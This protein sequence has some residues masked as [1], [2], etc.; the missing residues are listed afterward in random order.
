MSIKAIVVGII[1][2]DAFE[3][4]VTLSF[5]NIRCFLHCLLFSC[6]IL[7]LLFILL[8]LLLSFFPKDVDV[9]VILLDNAPHATP[10]I[11]V[12]PVESLSTDSAHLIAPYVPLSSDLTIQHSTRVRK[13]PSYL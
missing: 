7:L 3:S 5:G 13:V 8:I 11:T 1:Y 2:L 10:L 6:L 12:Y 9:P 4:L